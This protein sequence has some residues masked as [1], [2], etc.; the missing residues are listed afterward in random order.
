MYEYVS[1][2]WRINNS[3]SSGATLASINWKIPHEIL[4][5]EKQRK[6]QSEIIS[7]RRL[8]LFVD[9]LSEILS[10]LLVFNLITIGIS[11]LIG[12]VVCLLQ[13]LKLFSTQ[14]W[15]YQLYPYIV[16]IYIYL[17]LMHSWLFVTFLPSF[18]CTTL[19]YYAF[20]NA[21]KIINFIVIHYNCPY[22]ELSSC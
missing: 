10:W 21:F 4:Q 15:A 17:H 11:S 8:S 6:C 22:L 1:R 16:Y 13:H 5:R 7:N 12:T 9:I 3:G 14:R 19:I 20:Y 2:K 18:I